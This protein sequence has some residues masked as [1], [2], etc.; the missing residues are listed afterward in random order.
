MDGMPKPL[1]DKVRSVIEKRFALPVFIRTDQA[2]GKHFWKDSCFY[3]GSRPLDRHLFSVCEAN[4]CAD[5]IGL[6]FK[7]IVIREYIPMDSLFTAFWGNLPISP[8]RR[9]FIKAGKILCRHAYWFDEAIRTPSAENWKEL[10]ARMNLQT[11]VEVKLLTKYCGLV[12]DVFRGYWSVDFCR[13]K[14]GRWILID[15]A[16][17]E[18][19]WHPKDCPR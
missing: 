18:K 14:D 3:D 15:M 17:G 5:I 9:Y 2:S 7:A 1:I 13:A 16:E 11:D 19:S 12:A 4:H 6:Y 10:N 8:E